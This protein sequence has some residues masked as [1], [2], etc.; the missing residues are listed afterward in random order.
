MFAN[1]EFL[2]QKNCHIKT[3][4]KV[5]VIYGRAFFVNSSACLKTTVVPTVAYPIEEILP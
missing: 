4:T 3:P 1:N 2:E 5:V